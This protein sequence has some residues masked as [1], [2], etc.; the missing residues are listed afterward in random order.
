MKHTMNKLTCLGIALLAIQ[1]NLIAQQLDF[2]VSYTL[3]TYTEFSVDDAV[4]DQLL[5]QD[6]IKL[7]P[8]ASK[9]L[10]TEKFYDDG[11]STTEV[12][13][14]RP[15][16]P[17]ESWLTDID[18]IA[19][20]DDKMEVYSAGALAFE[21][22]LPM[23]ETT[24]TPPIEFAAYYLATNNWQL[25]LPPDEVIQYTDNGF[26][27]VQNTPNV[28]EIVCDSLSLKYNKSNWT[29]TLVKFYLAGD[30]SF[31][32]I[33]AYEPNEAGYL[34]YN[35]VITWSVDRRL[36]PCIQ[37]IVYQTYSNI[38][39][40]FH[41]PLCAPIEENGYAHAKVHTLKKLHVPVYQLEGTNT[42]FVD[43][44]LLDIE[45]V[46]VIIKDIYGVTVIDNLILE[47]DWPYL[48]L[49]EL[50]TGVYSVHLDLP[51]TSPSKFIFK[52]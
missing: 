32:Q 19:V 36:Q 17:L 18:R 25:P 2:E 5:P 40:I 8:V 51:Y 35:Y 13:I 45:A 46:G 20:H 7:L 24:R 6:T 39:R 15:I 21:E 3:D 38:H 22:I 26:D 43:T 16:K 23:E 9:E 11:S 52:P 33:V 49:G 10:M 1:P 50:P 34:L 37:K 27:V 41:N 14:S 4:A 12:H 47:K 48:T 31:R 44:E 30:E 42:I 28:L 29:E